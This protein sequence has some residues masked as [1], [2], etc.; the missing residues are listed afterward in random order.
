[1]PNNEVR[2]SSWNE[3]MDQLFAE[4]WQEPLGRFR[5][6]DVFRGMSNAEYE[7]ATGLARLGGSPE[8]EDHMLR[9]FRRYAYQPELA[10]Y[11][12]WNWLALAQHHGLSTRLL[13]WTY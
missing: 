8:L 9:A 2:V 7:L 11:S 12:V 5:T 1:M 6:N 10:H 3:L 13:D 4:A